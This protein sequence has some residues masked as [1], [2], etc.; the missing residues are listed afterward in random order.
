MIWR[1]SSSLRIRSAE[2][3]D[4]Y[5]HGVFRL[6]KAGWISTTQIIGVDFT[7]IWS[8]LYDLHRTMR[9]FLPRPFCL[10]VLPN[11][12]V[13]RLPLPL[14]LPLPSSWFVL[15]VRLVGEG[16]DGP[17]EVDVEVLMFMLLSYQLDLM[18]Y[19]RYWMSK[20]LL[21][22]PICC[23]YPAGQCWKTQWVLALLSLENAIVTFAKTR[24]AQAHDGQCV[25]PRGKHSN[26]TYND[27]SIFEL[28]DEESHMR[29][30]ALAL[31]MLVYN[32]D[33]IVTGRLEAWQKTRQI[34]QLW[35]PTSF[36]LRAPT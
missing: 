25:V 6:W 34:V 13:H 2:I 28:D 21:M 36:N 29:M 24:C 3:R 16:L 32:A 15:V 17:A 11:I 20:R 23:W 26:T 35:S 8:S 4:V 12:S 18:W 5:V 1:I 14:P 31:A 9:F 33:S 22:I 27:T 19:P 10:S 30:H 7:A